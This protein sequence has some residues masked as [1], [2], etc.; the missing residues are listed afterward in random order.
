[1]AT[2]DIEAT[3]LQIKVLLKEKKIKVK[4]IAEKLGF[5]SVYPVYKWIN[6]Q[7]MPTLDNL[8][9]LADLLDVKVD[10]VLVVKKP[11]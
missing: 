1:M 8:V 9:M 7:T 4:D 2:L 10:D 6:G 11:A 3:G 5:A